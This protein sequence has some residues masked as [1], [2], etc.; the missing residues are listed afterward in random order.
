MVTVLS[1]CQPNEVEDHND[2]DNDDD[3]DDDDDDNDDDDDDD[4]VDTRLFR[5]IGYNFDIWPVQTLNDI[6]QICLVCYRPIQTTH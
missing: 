6:M 1:W 5:T 2:D 3:D 4:D